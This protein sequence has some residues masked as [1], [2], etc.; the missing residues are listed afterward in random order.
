MHAAESKFLAAASKVDVGKWQSIDVSDR[1]EMVTHELL[2]VSFEIMLPNRIETLQEVVK[3]NLPW[4]EDHF[5]ERVSGEPWNPP[6][7]E[8]WWPHNRNKGN[9][10]FKAQDKFSHTYPERF[11]PKMAG[12]GEA[13]P[14][15]REIF[16]PHV[17][18][19]FAYG[20]LG[21]VIFQ[22]ASDRLTRQAYL[23]VWFPEDTGAVHGQRVPCTLGYHFIIRNNALHCIYYIRS[24]DF[25][26]HF[27]D[28]VYMAWRLTQWIVQELDDP[29]LNTGKLT[30]HITSFHI[31]D[32]DVPIL[33]SQHGTA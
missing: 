20:D 24:C 5:Q 9:D 16:V 1:P 17:G 28:D 6:P 19:R 3:P 32:G 30:M 2:N 31:F 26:R 12:V 11:W 29:R 18:V 33:R 10:Q 4:A 25:M 14:E 21:D 23:P 22:L 13:T 27:R 15:G 8:A 7:S